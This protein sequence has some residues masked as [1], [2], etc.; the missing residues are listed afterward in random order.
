MKSGVAVD[1]GLAAGRGTTTNLVLVVVAGLH[2][3]AADLTLGEAV[4]NFRLFVR[5]FVRCS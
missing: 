5:V 3:A 4:R 1:A 2:D